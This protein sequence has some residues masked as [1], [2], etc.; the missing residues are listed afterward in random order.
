M[1]VTIAIM[2]VAIVGIGGSLAQ[3]QKIAGISQDQA[4]LQVAMR[5]LS[6]YVRD[7]SASGLTYKLCAK[8]TDY[9]SSKMPALPATGVTSWGVS[10]VTLSTAGARNSVPVAPIQY[11]VTANTCD[12]T[13]T[14]DWGVQELTLF[15]ANGSRTLTR[16]IWKSAS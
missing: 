2:T 15:V 5:Q 4:Q 16:T 10:A 11:C 14:C 7:S 13:H 3:S 6:D 9:P 1:I 12:S 8:T